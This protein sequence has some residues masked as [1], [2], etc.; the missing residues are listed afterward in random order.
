MIRRGMVIPEF[1]FALSVLPVDA[2]SADSFHFLFVF[3]ALLF[4]ALRAFTFF[5]K[6]RSFVL[7]YLSGSTSGANFERSYWIMFIAL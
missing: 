1:H 3:R 2:V 7:S 6:A 4:F 5:R